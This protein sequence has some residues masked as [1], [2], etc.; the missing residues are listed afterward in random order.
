MVYLDFLG[1]LYIF[2]TSETGRKNKTSNIKFN[3]HVLLSIISI[4]LILKPSPSFV[5]FGL[6]TNFI[7]PNGRK[8]AESWTSKL[9]SRSGSCGRPALARVASASFCACVKN[10]AAFHRWGAPRETSACS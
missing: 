4:G 9:Q 8:C 10:Q 6:T 1:P 7:G 2:F 5:F 3:L